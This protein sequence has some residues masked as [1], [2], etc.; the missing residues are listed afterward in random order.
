MSANTSRSPQGHLIDRDGLLDRFLSY[1]RIWTTSDEASETTP[2]SACQWDLARLLES[3]LRDVGLDDV[4]L[5]DSGYVYGRLPERLPAGSSRTGQIP[6][7]GLVAHMDVSPQ[8]SGRNVKPIVHAQYDGGPIALPGAPDVVLTPED[9]PPLGECVG[10]DVVTSDGTTLLG[11]DDK[12][13]IAVIMT[14]LETL[15]RHPEIEHGPIAAAFTVDEEIGRGVDKFDLERFGAEVAYT[16]DGSGVG[17][18]ED[19][20]FCA[21]TMIVTVRGRNVH[22]GYAKGKLVN[23]MKV[24]ADLLTRLPKDRLS[25]ETTDGRDGYVHPHA[26]EGNEERTVI[27]LLIRDFTVQ[28]LEALEAMIRRQATA[29]ERSYPGSTIAIEVKPSY[30]NMKVVLDRRPEATAFAVEAIRGAGLPVIR[31]PVRG[32]TDGARLSFMGLPTPNL[33]AGGHNFHSKRE[34]VAVQHMERSVEVVLR[35]VGIWAERGERK[36]LLDVSR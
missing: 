28:G 29:V 11:A 22:P 26:L 15:Q 1:A 31:K 27:R 36:G 23:S 21:D 5:D 35:L 6:T 16:I 3:E 18:I 4:H 19:E 7:V 8:V 24:A 9:D 32:G 10:L 2:S 34:W 14:A 25:P 33:F 12:A 20:T 13:G 30:R 17:E